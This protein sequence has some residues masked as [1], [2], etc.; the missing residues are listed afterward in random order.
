[1]ANNNNAF[2]D[3]VVITGASTGIGAALARRLAKQGAHLALGA[4][5]VANLDRVAGECRDLGG[6]ALSVPTDVGLED[7]CRDLIETTLE[8]YGRIDM[9]INNAGFSVNA[10][11]DELPALNAFRRVM[12]V[13]LMGS[14]YCAYY[15]L[16]HLKKTRG[17]IVAV[18]SM[19]GKAAAPFNTSYAASKSA[20]AA[21]F[22]TLRQE[23]HWHD[24]GVSVTMV[25]PDYVVTD[26]LAN[27]QNAS[28]D[29]Y[30]QE[31][32]DAF[33]NDKMMSADTCARIILT[34]AARRRR[35]VY[36]TTRTKFVPLLRALMPR[37]VDRI[38]LKLMTKNN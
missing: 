22:D 16:P 31:A 10:P 26:F 21:F 36:T 35:E 3:S 23:Q 13:N 5:G 6:R 38:A 9:L 4:R 37:A 33:Y 15:A 11:F 17:R 14:V 8:E 27:I 29:L 7:Q 2:K 30:G 32:A 18:S 19:A 28:G 34:A 12:D 20:M 1:M 25:Y 24:S